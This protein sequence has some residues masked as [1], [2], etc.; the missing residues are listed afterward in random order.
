MFANSLE[1]RGSNLLVDFSR[2]PRGY[3]SAVEETKEEKKGGKGGWTGQK[4]RGIGFSGGRGSEVFE[5]L[6]LCV[7]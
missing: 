5:C 4:V 7:V 6:Q 3:A 2:T 1:G